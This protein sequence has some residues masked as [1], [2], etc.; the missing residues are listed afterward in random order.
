MHLSLPI[1]SLLV[2]KA[3]A[4]G[5]AI[6]AAMSTISSA[7]VSLN[8]TV[9][10]F[11]SNP[12]LDLL[13]IGPL[14]SDSLTLLNDINAAT[15]IAQKSANLSLTD[16]VSVA[17]STL[18]LAS[19]VES[20][21]T[22]IVNSK[23]KFDKLVVVSPVILLNLKEEKAATDKFGAAVVSKVPPALQATAQGLLAPIDDAFNSAIATYEEFALRRKRS[24]RM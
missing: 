1:L 9:S 2:A 14:L 22:N 15:S 20:T 23:P 11:P 12:V 4:D 10:S 24:V 13:D 18:S 21:L 19:T 17:Q 8:N 5:A 6:V 7:T 3:A 16:A